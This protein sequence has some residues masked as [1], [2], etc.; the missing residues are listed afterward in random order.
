VPPDAIVDRLEDE[1]RIDHADDSLLLRL[2]GTVLLL[3]GVYFAVTAILGQVRVLPGA[4][5]RAR[6]AALGATVLFAAAGSGLLSRGAFPDRWLEW[7][8]AGLSVLA[9]AVVAGL[10]LMR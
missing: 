10:H 5:A 1:P 8:A 6:V 7:L 3:V 9:V 2:S 4:G